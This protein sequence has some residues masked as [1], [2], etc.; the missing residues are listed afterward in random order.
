M[1]VVVESHELVEDEDTVREVTEYPVEGLD[2][3]ERYLWIAIEE[4][5]DPLAGINTITGRSPGFC[6]VPRSLCR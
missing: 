6:W 2:S 5:S 4:V 1:S 3:S